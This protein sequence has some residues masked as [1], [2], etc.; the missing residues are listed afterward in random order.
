MFEDMNTLREHCLSCRKCGL[1]ET[2]TQVVF[3][4]GNPQAE[5]LFIGEGPGEQEDLT[6]EPFVGR[7]GQ[8]LDKMLFAVDLSRKENIYIANIVK[9]R[10]PKNRDPL[11]E[12][13]E[14]C[15]DYLRNQVLLIRPKIIVCLGRIAA[16]KLLKPDFKVTREHGVWFEKNGV[17]MMGTFHPAALL[18]NPASKPAA[19]ED[20]FALRDKIQEICSHTYPA[21]EA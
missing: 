9:C 12:E 8:L 2:R 3:G 17:Q 16:Q 1:C 21:E 11:P 14:A 7:G 20:F 6:G 10:P 5:I 15:I 4:V 13:Q 19:M 18:R